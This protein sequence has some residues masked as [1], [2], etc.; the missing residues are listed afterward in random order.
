MERRTF[1]LVVEVEEV[2]CMRDGGSLEV[3]NWPGWY[4]VEHVTVEMARANHLVK[5]R[6]QRLSLRLV[7]L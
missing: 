3:N 4:A 6:E 5:A 1:L 2:E 7:N